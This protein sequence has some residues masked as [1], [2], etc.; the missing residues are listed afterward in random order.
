MKGIVFRELLNMVATTFDENMVD[1][2]L[3]DCTLKSNGSYTS[4][5]TYDHMEIIQ[6]VQSLSKKTDIPQ[7][8]LFKSYGYYLFSR[9]HSLMP[10]FF[11]IPKDTFE[12]LESIDQTIHIEVKKLYPDAM[13]PQFTTERTNDDTL[14]MIY[15]SRCPFA[16]FASGLITGCI[17]HFKEN[18]TFET[19]DKN[20][21]TY[22]VRH[23]VLKHH[24]Q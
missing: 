20:D 18:I 21:D 16:D 24:G 14:K 17:D 15:Q 9:F 2:I 12:F 10:Q 5:G 11:I 6:I 3:D 22:Y 1:D 4:A 8:E 13:L 19:E 23:F 7:A